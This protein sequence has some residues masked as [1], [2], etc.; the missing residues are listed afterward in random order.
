MKVTKALTPPINQ[1][2]DTSRVKKPTNNNINT[3]FTR[4]PTQ[5]L[6]TEPNHAG[7][8]TQMSLRLIEI[9]YPRN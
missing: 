5:T 9:L 3:K 4:Q 1:D 7:T 8:K 2:P 6:A